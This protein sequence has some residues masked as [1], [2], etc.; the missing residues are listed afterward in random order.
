MDNIITCTPCKNPP[1]KSKPNKRS[2]GNNFKLQQQTRCQKKQ[3]YDP[4][5]ANDK[6]LM[7]ELMDLANCCIDGK[8]N[9]CLINCFEKKSNGYDK[10]ALDKALELLR[11]CRDIVRFKNKEERSI[12]LYNCFQESRFKTTGSTD[13]IFHKWKLNNNQVNV[14]YEFT[15]FSFDFAVYKLELHSS[16]LFRFVLKHFALLMDLLCTK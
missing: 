7:K 16:I 14:V 13:K 11:E 8:E 6:I 4:S 15:F 5:V 2:M 9:G 3:K 1:E 10:H 12:F